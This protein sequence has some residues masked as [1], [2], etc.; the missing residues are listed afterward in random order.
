VAPDGRARDKLSTETAS[1][2]GKNPTSRGGVWRRSSTPSVVVDV[3][4]TIAAAFRERQR[5]AG[6]PSVDRRRHRCLLLTSAIVL[7]II[8]FDSVGASFTVYDL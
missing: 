2:V 6:T 1:D 3:V 5:R 4:A 7:T 8:P